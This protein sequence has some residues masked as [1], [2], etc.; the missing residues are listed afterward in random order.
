MTIPLTKRAIVP[1]PRR[2]LN[3]AV[4][5]GTYVGITSSKEKDNESDTDISGD[6]GSK[7]S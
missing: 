7:G 5:I 4:H 2:V 3:E 6:I 1:N